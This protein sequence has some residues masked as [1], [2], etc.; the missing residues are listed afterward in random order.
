MPSL[1]ACFPCLSEEAL[2]LVPVLGESESEAS[3]LAVHTLV[4]NEFEASLHE[5][6]SLTLK[7]KRETEARM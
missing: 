1:T 5:T 7:K 3:L 2:D 4:H 6:P